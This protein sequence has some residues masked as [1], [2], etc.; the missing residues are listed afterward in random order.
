MLSAFETERWFAADL[1]YV[2]GELR[3]RFA[4]ELGFGA[5]GNV[6]ADHRM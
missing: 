5:R 4:E 2:T 3:L 1:S 6:G